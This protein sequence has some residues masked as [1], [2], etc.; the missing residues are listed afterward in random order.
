MPDPDRLARPLEESVGPGQRNHDLSDGCV[1]SHTSHLDACRAE[2]KQLQ[3][4]LD[5]AIQLMNDQTTGSYFVLADNE[6][7]Q[8]RLATA[9]D[10]NTRL[11][12]QVA[13]KTENTRLKARLAQKTEDYERLWSAL[14]A[15][16]E[17]ATRV[18]GEL[19]ERLAAELAVVEAARF[20][21]SNEDSRIGAMQG[22]YALRAA[23]DHLPRTTGKT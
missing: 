21:A 16:V 13:K 10:E 8:T 1:P 19:R 11:K 23:L 12:A 9:L 7:L 2:N 6:R 18:R 4:Q 14:Q 20:V 5:H 17:T 15:E 22:V 3:A